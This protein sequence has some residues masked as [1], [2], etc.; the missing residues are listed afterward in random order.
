MKATKTNGKPANNK[1]TNDQSKAKTTL[2]TWAD[3]TKL[4]LTDRAFF[5][6]EDGKTKRIKLM[7]PPV[8]AHVQFVPG[9]GFI[10]TLSDY[11]ERNGT[12]VCKKQG[13]DVELLGKEPML[14]WM[15]PVLVYETDK[16][17]QISNPNNFSYEF[18][19]WS[20]YGSDYKRMYNMVVD[21]GEEEFNSKDLLVTGV[22]KGKYVNAELSLAAKN[23]LCLN[24][25]VA[26]EIESAFS[27]YQFRDVGRFIARTVTEEELTEAVEKMAAGANKE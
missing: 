1:A 26:D 21:H 18:Q 19:L 25:A 23:A 14:M 9:L 15:T 17:G 2:G 24:S 10:H 27:A 12:M 13:L 4:G 8:R 11:E 3:P 16:K 7:A 6:A 20:F 5:K 22:K